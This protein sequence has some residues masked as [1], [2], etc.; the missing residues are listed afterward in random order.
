[1]TGVPATVAAIKAFD[2]VLYKRLYGQVRRAVAVI[3]KDAASAAPRA[4]G[5]MASNYRVRKARG[6]AYSFTFI[7][8]NQTVQ[9]SI[10]E[11][12][13]SVSQGRTPQGRSLISALTRTYGEPGRFAWDAYDRNHAEVV[14]QS[15]ALVKAAEA[16]MQAALNRA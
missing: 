15:A 16:Q 12:A 1:V 13:G 10:L 4:T 3:A 5:E 2:K 6:G 7:V 8:I 11:H 14:A 9:G